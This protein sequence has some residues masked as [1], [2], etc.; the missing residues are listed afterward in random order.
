[1]TVELTGART[2]CVQCRRPSPHDRRDIGGFV[3]HA[4]IILL[5]ILILP[6]AA[7]PSLGADWFFSS[8]PNG[9]TGTQDDPWCIQ[10][11][12]SGGGKTSFAFLTDGNSPATPDA[13]PGDTIHLCCNEPCNEAGFG[14]N[15]CVYRVEPSGTCDSH[16]YWISPQVDGITI[17]TYCTPTR[18]AANCATVRISGDLNDNCKYDTGELD[19]F[20]DNED[21]GTSCDHAGSGN[22]DNWTIQGAPGDL[23]AFSEAGNHMFNMDGNARGW[24]GWVFDYIDGSHATGGKM[25]NL[26]SEDGTYG[27]PDNEWDMVRRGCVGTKEGH[28]FKYSKLTGPLT[29]KRS[30]FHDS[31]GLTD[32]GIR[33]FANPAADVLFED[34]EIYD[35]RA[36]DPHGPLVR[37]DGVMQG[38][39]TWRRNYLHDSGPIIFQ[40][41]GRNILI[42]DNILACLGEEH[43]DINFK[44]WTC[45]TAI[46]IVNGDSSRSGFFKCDSDDPPFC[47]QNNVI[48]RRNIIYGTNGSGSDGS[49]GNANFEAGIMVSPRNDDGLPVDCTIENNILWNVRARFSSRELALRAAIG[50]NTE[51]A[52]FCTIQNNTVYNSRHALT[53]RGGSNPNI[54]RNNIF[55]SNTS[56]N[57]EVGIL[58]G[59]QVFANN[60]IY[61]G[62]LGGDIVEGQGTFTCATV[63]SFGASNICAATSFVDVSDPDQAN[64]DLHLDEGDAANR[65]AGNAT[66]ASD[67]IDRQERPNPSDGLI[68]IGADEVYAGQ[69]NLP[70]TASLTLAPVPPIDAGNISLLK[71]R[72]WTIT[73]QANRDLVN[74]PAPLTFKDSGGIDHP[75]ALAGNLPGRV[76]TGAF[77]VDASITEGAGTFSLAPDAL[78]D[79][80]GNSGNEITAGKSVI[81]DLTAPAAPAG[82]TAE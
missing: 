38:S 49:R 39:W 80:A 37:A 30:K 5:G 41:N 33:A 19:H 67:D 55:S 14:A 50:V 27:C 64:W 59:I 2:D 15:S 44:E 76:F 16:P 60:N 7:T 21:V 68:D 66:G 82:V 73:L 51:D 40:E 25:L 24:G 26:N 62:G 63:G 8:C 70:P 34:N 72:S 43:A 61:D 13:G 28:M 53:I 79:A 45:G 22:G 10:N 42:E 77:L 74:I 9:G 71:G 57:P 35:V 48:I 46:R 4:L 65:D 56:D 32:R 11:E 6:V 23:L 18:D 75:I 31:C 29:V 12:H 78:V 81:I 69:I 52:S 54:I 17:Q 3:R 58:A 36:A 1:M 47:A 20:L